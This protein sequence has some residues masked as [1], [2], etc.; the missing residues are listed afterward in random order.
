M[1]RHQQ[2]FKPYHHQ[3]Q[4]LCHYG[5]DVQELHGGVGEPGDH[6]HGGAPGPVFPQGKRHCGFLASCGLGWSR[7]TIM[8][9][10]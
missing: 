3:R 6:V 9:S 7:A 8:Q 1:P 2:P 4:P 10:C 5:E